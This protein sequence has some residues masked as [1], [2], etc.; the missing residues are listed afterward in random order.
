M[1]F[2]W[3][4]KMHLKRHLG[5]KKPEGNMLWRLRLFSSGLSRVQRRSVIWSFLVLH[6]SWEP[7]TS[8]KEA[9]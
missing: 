5:I 3:N 9:T 2:F 1:A 7:V 8:T 6:S 4:L